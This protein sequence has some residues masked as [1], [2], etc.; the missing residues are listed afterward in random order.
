MSYPKHTNSD[1]VHIHLYV[2]IRSEVNSNQTIIH[3]IAE[4]NYRIHDCVG[5]RTHICHYKMA[6]TVVF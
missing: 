3:R 2:D 5:S 1:M 4:V 6:L